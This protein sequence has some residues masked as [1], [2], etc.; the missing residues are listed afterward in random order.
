ML[1]IIGWLG[2]LMLAVKMAEMMANP[3]LRGEDGRMSPGLTIAL[4]VGWLGCAVFALLLYLQGT[5]FEAEPLDYGAQA[6][7]AGRVA[8]CMESKT[9]VDEMM[10]CYD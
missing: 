5:Q 2:C 8:D 7:E 4:L 6:E 1:Q 9:T 3:T 10:R